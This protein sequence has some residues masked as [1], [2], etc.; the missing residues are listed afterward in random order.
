MLIKGG[1]DADTYSRATGSIDRNGRLMARLLDDILEWSQIIEGKIVLRKVPV[2]LCG[3]IQ[4]AI[5]TLR[6]VADA[7]GVRFLMEGASRPRFAYGDSDRLR[8]I[9]WNLLSNAIK[10]SYANGEVKIRL[11]RDGAYE[12]TTVID[13]GPGI[14]DDFLPHVF[15]RFRQAESAGARTKGGVGLGLAI[16]RQLVELH[17][18]S[19]SAANQ[20]SGHG[21]VFTVRIPTASAAN[22]AGSRAT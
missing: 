20:K 9:V 2:E 18:G 14:D 10:F 11:E 22:A 5:E 4:S 12:K 8:E 13:S 7:K 21:A 19:V 17:G 15:E 6:P 3:L 1:L 16:V